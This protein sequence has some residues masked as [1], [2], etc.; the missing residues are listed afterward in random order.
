MLA[1]VFF[2]LFTLVPTAS[3]AGAEHPHLQ[4][5]SKFFNYLIIVLLHY[6]YFVFVEKEKNEENDDDLTTPSLDASVQID[7]YS[8]LYNV[9]YALYKE[10]VDL[11]HFD[12]HDGMVYC[13]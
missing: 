7:E 9:V 6:R 10:A 3:L 13:E 8:S 11:I 2:V 5:F 4:R 1:N 12:V